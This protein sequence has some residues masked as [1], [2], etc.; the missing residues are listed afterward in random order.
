MSDVPAKRRGK[1]YRGPF[2]NPRIAP[3]GPSNQ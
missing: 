3:F 1:A 2:A